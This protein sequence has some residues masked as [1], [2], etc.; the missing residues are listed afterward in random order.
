MRILPRYLSVLLLICL[1]LA[2]PVWAGPKFSW[3]N[4]TVLVYTRNGKGYVHDNIPSA[5]AALQLMAQQ[6]GFKVEVTDNP[7]VFTPENLKKFTLLLF[8]STN[9]EVFDT[10]E[11]RLAFRRYMQAGGGFVGLHSVL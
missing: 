4:V 6:Q 1:L 10:P 3:K 2:E 9:N 11:Q 5:V 7:A 8:P